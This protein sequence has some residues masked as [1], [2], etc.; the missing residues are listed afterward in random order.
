[1][2]APSHKLSTV[3]YS[4]G[5]MKWH[6]HTRVACTRINHIF[7]ARSQ[8]DENDFETVHIMQFS[9]T[10]AKLANLVTNN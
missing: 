4:W 6:M 2:K 5:K 8:S 9:E 1:M 3:A 10:S 7:M